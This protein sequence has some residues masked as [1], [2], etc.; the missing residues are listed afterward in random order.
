[1]FRLRQS[2][3]RLWAPNT[4]NDEMIFMALFK[5]KTASKVQDASDE[6]EF[7]APQQ[8]SQFEL[9]HVGPYEIVAPIGKWGD[10]HRL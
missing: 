1:M 9:T 2:P 5:R 10:G 7:A 3:E 8:T 4:E 6:Q